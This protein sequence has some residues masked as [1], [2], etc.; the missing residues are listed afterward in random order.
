[1]KIP[2]H[3][4]GI[5]SLGNP[6][7]DTDICYPCLICFTMAVHTVFTECIRYEYKSTI[8]SK[9][10]LFMSLVFIFTLVAPLLI[11]Y[12]SHGIVA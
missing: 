11:A 9:A 10:T 7:G 2:Q 1:M 3:I 12:R 4:S 6:V 5:E 8:C